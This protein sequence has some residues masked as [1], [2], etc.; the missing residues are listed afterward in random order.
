MT[1]TNS[2]TEGPGV[3]SFVGLLLGFPGLFTGGFFAMLW[4]LFRDYDPIYLPAGVL[5]PS[6]RAEDFLMGAFV[7]FVVA[8][9]GGTLLARDAH[10]A[11]RRAPA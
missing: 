3:A 8:G 4:V 11:W 2:V 9:L 1:T 5:P 6:E 7:A 10:R